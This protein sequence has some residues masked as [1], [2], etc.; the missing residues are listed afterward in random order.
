MVAR[1][2]EVVRTFFSSSTVT[3]NLIPA[4]LAGIGAVLCRST[5]SYTSIYITLNRGWGQNGKSKETPALSNP[6]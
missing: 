4:L 3:V 2:E 6:N 5:T 1:A